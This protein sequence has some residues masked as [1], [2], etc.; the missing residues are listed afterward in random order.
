M[1]QIEYKIDVLGEL[2]RAGWS[3]YRLRREK[4]F[5]EREMQRLRELEPVSWTVLA[6]ICDM[7]QCDVGDVIVF[8]GLRKEREEKVQG[9][10]RDVLRIIDE[11][12][13]AVELKFAE[14]GEQGAWTSRQLVAVSTYR[15]RLI[16]ALKEKV[17][18]RE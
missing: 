7:L 3:S 1:P 14:D 13:A 9:L 8:D 15:G 6:K 12:S 4:I 5:G 11:E 18:Q 10:M 16:D 17:G 2:K